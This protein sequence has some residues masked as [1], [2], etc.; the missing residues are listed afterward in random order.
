MN[1]L[2]ALRAVVCAHCKAYI[3]DPDFSKPCP[4]CGQ[5]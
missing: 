5:G 1:F 2:R 4:R 3:A